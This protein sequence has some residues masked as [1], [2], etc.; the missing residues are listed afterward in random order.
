MLGACVLVSLFACTAV[1]AAEQ[2]SRRWTNA[3]LGPDERASLILAR[4]TEVEQLS[5]VRGWL[6]VR[7]NPRNPPPFTGNKQFHDIVGS[8]G[9]VP[10]IPSLG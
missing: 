7:Y 2:T 1:P 5:L 10:G 3:K 9:Y 4:M 8:S 6:G